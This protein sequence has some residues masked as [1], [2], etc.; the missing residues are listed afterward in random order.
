M[1][2]QDVMI[3]DAVFEGGGV[4]GIGLVGALV[5]AEEKGYQWENMAGTSAGAVVASL[6]AAGYTATELKAILGE[7]DYTRFEDKSF[8]DKIPLIGK[9]ISLIFEKGIYEGDYLMN[10]IR[11]LLKE[12]GVCTFRDLLLP[13]YGDDNNY[14]FKLRV[15]ASDL[16]SRTMLVLPQDIEQYG[17][18]PKDLDV[19]LAVRMS[20]S[21]PFFYEPVRLKDKTTNQD[22]YIVDGGLLS[23]FPVWLFDTPGVTNSWPTFG[24]KLFDPGTERKIGGPVSLLKELYS[25]MIEARDARHIKNVNFARTIAIPVLGI[26]ATEFG[27]SKEKSEALYQSG[28]QAAERFFDTYNHDT[29]VKRF[30]V[31][32]NTIGTGGSNSL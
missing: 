24:F 6:L 28:R 14:K 11:S 25:T 19:A 17:V 16:S 23:N 12:K 22:C 29:F 30:L 15:I 18:N 5:V 4:R 26:G 10:W 8:I 27:L 31:D 20:M 32:A 3:A 21:I 7:L 13:E 1:K 9:L 2:S